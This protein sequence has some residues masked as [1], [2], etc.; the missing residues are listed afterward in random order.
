LKELFD[1]IILLSEI[2][3]KRENKEACIICFDVRIPRKK[4]IFVD[5]F[6]QKIPSER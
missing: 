4:N 2:F 1:E 6:H 3:N 5:R